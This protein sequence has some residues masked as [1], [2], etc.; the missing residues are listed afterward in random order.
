MNKDI[1]YSILFLNNTG[2]NL[3]VGLGTVPSG[4]F[5]LSNVPYGYG[6]DCAL[7]RSNGT[8]NKDFG[9]P[10]GICK[11]RIKYKRCNARAPNTWGNQSFSVT[12]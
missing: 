10:W 8:P 7:T 2:M 3:W 6:G 12:T 11:Q 1:H 5:C 9:R 4:I